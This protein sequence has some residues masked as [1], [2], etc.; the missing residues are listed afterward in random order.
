M[1]L[2]DSLNILLRR[3]VLTVPLLLLTI[4]GVVAAFLLLPW[5]YEAKANAVFLASPLQAK[6]A[7]GNPWLVFDGSL[8][9]TAEVVGREMMDAR[10]V[11]DLKARGLTSEYLVA[12]AA[13]TTGPVLEITVTGSDARNTEG[14]LAALTAMIP[15]K[16]ERIQAENGVTPRARITS[17]VVTSSPRADLKATDKIRNVALLLFVGGAMTVAV[18]LFV[19]SVASRR[20]QRDRDRRP[21][22]FQPPALPPGNGGGDEVRSGNGS[23]APPPDPRPTPRAARA[24]R[25]GTAGPPAQRR[26]PRR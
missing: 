4:S 23:F 22:P 5:S 21:A 20:Q 9:V 24:P 17:K 16:L 13:N 12:V 2:L 15:Q 1:D 7:G 19:E 26:D 14:T 6:Q 10:T 11:A 8:T 25:N 3:W 18:P